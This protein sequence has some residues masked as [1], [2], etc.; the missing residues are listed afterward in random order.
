MLQSRM[1]VL[2][3]NEQIFLYYYCLTMIPLDYFILYNLT[4]LVSS[5]LFNAESADDLVRNICKFL[6]GF[7]LQSGKTALQPLSCPHHNK[8][9]V[10]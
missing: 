8:E 5:N 7:L 1:P 9:S 2:I 6:S 10:P 3:R 4:I